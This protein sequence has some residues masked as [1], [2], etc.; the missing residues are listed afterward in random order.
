M[1]QWS[2]IFAVIAVFSGFIGMNDVAGMTTEFAYLSLFIGLTFALVA[3][4][5][6]KHP[7]P[8][9]RRKYYRH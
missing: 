6:G 5:R 4:L 7:R 3:V 9:Y 8:Q 2:L 1:F